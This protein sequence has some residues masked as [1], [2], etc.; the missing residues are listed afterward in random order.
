[1]QKPIADLED[2]SRTCDAVSMYV[3]DAAE[4]E[5]FFGKI[6]GAVNRFRAQAHDEQEAAQLVATASQLLEAAVNHHRS[7]SASVTPNSVRVYDETVRLLVLIMST[8]LRMNDSVYDEARKMRNVLNALR[9]C[10]ISPP[11]HF[12]RPYSPRYGNG[13]A[14]DAA[15]AEALHYARENIE[16]FTRSIYNLAYNNTFILDPFV[17]GQ[18]S[19]ALSLFERVRYL[20]SGALLIGR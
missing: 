11:G 16:E 1:M 4:F 6:Y 9:A 2:L 7:E 18:Q 17:G 5:K 8:D 19:A 13:D 3:M 15:R 12:E 14:A 20:G 10:G